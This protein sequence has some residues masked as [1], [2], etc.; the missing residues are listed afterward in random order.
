M[1]VYAVEVSLSLLPS[2]SHFTKQTL[3]FFNQLEEN[4]L[5]EK[6]VDPGVEDRIEGCKANGLEIGVLLQP[7]LHWGLIKLVQKHPS[8][9]EI[10]NE[11]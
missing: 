5:A 2:G 4:G 1:S 8:L 6:D 3:D 11:M 10:R 9:K 7:Q